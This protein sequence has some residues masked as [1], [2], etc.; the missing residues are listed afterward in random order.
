MLENNISYTCDLLLLKQNQEK[1]HL[2]SE[3]CLGKLLLLSTIRGMFLILLADL[4]HHEVAPSPVSALFP[5][6]ATPLMY[7]QSDPGNL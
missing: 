4:V 3:C 6:P 5:L 1:L 2:I 7:L